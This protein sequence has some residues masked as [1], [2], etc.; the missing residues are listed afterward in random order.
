MNPITHFLVSW[1]V[2]NVIPSER[3]DRTLITIAGVIPDIDGFGAIP[4][5]LTRNSDYPLFWWTNYHH[6]LGHNLTF[7]LLVTIGSFAI[8][9]KRWKTAILSFLAF[10]LH[11]LGDIIGARGP[12]GYQWPIPY[13]YP[14]SDAWQLVWGGQW[15]LNAWPNFVVTGAALF[16]AFYIAWKRGYSPLEMIS[17]SANQAVIQTL[18]NRFGNP[19]NTI[20]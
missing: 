8:A 17:S 6:I 19:G 10:H 14:F 7:G 16:L 5:L 12:D 4:E 20:K 2:A 18:R 15:A 13:L 1:G 3:K 11:L 9:K